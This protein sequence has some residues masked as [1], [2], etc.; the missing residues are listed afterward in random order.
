MKPKWISWIFVLSDIFT[1][2]V[3]AGGGGMLATSDPDRAKLG[4]Q[5][6]LAGIVLQ[7]VSFALFTVLWLIFTCRA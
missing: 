4:S 5:I 7:L 1:F 3:Q 6:F 2:L